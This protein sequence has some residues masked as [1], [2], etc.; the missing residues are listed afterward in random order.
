MGR[1]SIR[2]SLQGRTKQ[3]EST[4]STR[5]NPGPGS[6]K[7][8]IEI[9]KDGIYAYGKFKN[10]LAPTFSLPSFPRFKT[11]KVSNTPGPGQYNPKTSIVDPSANFLSNISSPKTR[12]L[13]QSERTTIDIPKN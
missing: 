5:Y 8:N 11:Q 7:P 13:Y 9:N 4:N 3:Y 12:T 1:D 10:S 6:Y 2:V